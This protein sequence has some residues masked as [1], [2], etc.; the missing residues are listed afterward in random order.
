MSWMIKTHSK[1]PLNN[2]SWKAANKEIIYAQSGIPNETNHA[3]KDS[4]ERLKYNGG[5]IKTYSSQG[6]G[7]RGEGGMLSDRPRY[8]EEP[9]K[10][11]VWGKS[12][13]KRKSQNPDR[14]P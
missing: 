7:L 2:D 6:R 12:Q 4:T 11:M 9:G 3:W 8:H 14:N 1:N 13:L 10:W 5:L